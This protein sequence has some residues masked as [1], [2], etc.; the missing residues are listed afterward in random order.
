MMGAIPEMA[1]GRLQTDVRRRL[2]RLLVPGQVGALPGG[3]V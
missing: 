3:G 1:A 2:D